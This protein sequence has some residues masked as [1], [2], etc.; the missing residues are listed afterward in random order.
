M[1][2]KNKQIAI[3]GGGPGGLT[4]ANLLQ[5]KG[6]T[7]RV[8]ERDE[9]KHARVQGAT[10][11]LHEES[12]LSQDTIRKW[13]QTATIVAIDNQG[14]TVTNNQLPPGCRKNAAC[15]QKSRNQTR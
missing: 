7:I 11:D 15:Y 4:L 8:Y 6:A 10:L 1:L 3:I 12:G 14:K 9:N 2:L 5:Q 13:V